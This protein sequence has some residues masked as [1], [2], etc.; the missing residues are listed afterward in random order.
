VLSPRLTPQKSKIKENKP[1]KLK[2]KKKTKRKG[3]IAVSP[4]HITSSPR[5]EKK[6]KTHLDMELKKPNK[7]T[8]R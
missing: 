3:L 5:Q 4:P 6:R 7:R 8:P 2:K 1:Q